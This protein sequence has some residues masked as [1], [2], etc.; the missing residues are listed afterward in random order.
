MTE[1][2]S[3][4][5]L[6]GVETEID[7]NIIFVQNTRFTYA[8]GTFEDA[9]TYDGLRFNLG[10]NG[11][12]IASDSLASFV[13]DEDFFNEDSY[14]HTNFIMQ[15]VID[16]VSMDTLTLAFEDLATVRNVSLNG[17]ITVPVGENHTVPLIIDYS[18]LLK[19]ADFSLL[20]EESQKNAILDNLKSSF[21]IE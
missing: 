2:L 4:T 14:V 19:G 9:M 6:N 1:D 12:Y 16:T 10:I 17:E 21:V 11:N 15:Y 20:G 3:V 8:V 5:G 18:L 7:D 13:E